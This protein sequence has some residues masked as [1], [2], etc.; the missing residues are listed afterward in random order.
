MLH[1]LNS[2]RAWLVASVVA[3]TVIV[4]TVVLMLFDG[5]IGWLM[6]LLTNRRI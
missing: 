3:A 4:F 6:H 2:R 5:A 1:R